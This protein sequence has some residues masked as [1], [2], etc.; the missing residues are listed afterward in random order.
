MNL[1]PKRSLRR[2]PC[3]TI[4]CEW[5]TIE[6]RESYRI[7]STFLSKCVKWKSEVM[8][9]HQINFHFQQLRKDFNTNFVWFKFLMLC[10]EHFLFRLPF[11]QHFLGM[12]L[13]T[14]C[15]VRVT[16][17]FQ[18]PMLLRYITN[19]NWKRN[20]I[21]WLLSVPNLSTKKKFC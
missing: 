14:I 19:L 13:G 16:Q 21:F 3:L 2:I 20:D 11:R 12:I 18:L 10:N 8:D 7:F 5:S 15:N 1:F 9:S 17:M 6:N 4:L